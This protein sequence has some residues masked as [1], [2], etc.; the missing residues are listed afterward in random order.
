MG[1]PGPCPPMGGGCF[2]PP[3]LLS[4]KPTD[5]HLE[6]GKHFEVTSL[7][8]YGAQEYGCDINLNVIQNAIDLPNIMI[9][10][11]WTG[12]TEQHVKTRE[13][14]WDCKLAKSSIFLQK[15]PW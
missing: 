1:I 4:A 2:A 13:R 10:F 9:Y 8:Y 15:E 14:W 12:F 5:G 6:S 11:K 3:P 7:P